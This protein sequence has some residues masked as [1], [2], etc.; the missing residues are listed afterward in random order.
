VVA[1]EPWELYPSVWK[2]ESSFWNYLRG[3]FR[4][5]W[6]RYPPK[7]IW[8]ESQ[9][10]NPPEGFVGRAKKVGECHYCGCLF[11][12]S[13]LEVDHVEQ[14][15]TCNSWESAAEFLHNLLDCN[16]NW[17]LAC[18]PC[19]KIKS[20]AERMGVPFEQA[21]VEKR[22]IEYEKKGVGAVTELCTKHGYTA[23]QLSNPSKRR[24]ALKEVIEKHGSI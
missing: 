11:A 5:I 2:T 17:V 7:L 6:S 21:M 8:K 4:K 3:G 12:K 19:H 1:K 23:T 13:S 10:T 9:V 18:K 20:Y 22:V 15:G 14:A 16:S 24:Q